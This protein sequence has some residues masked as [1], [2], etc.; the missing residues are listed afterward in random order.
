MFEDFRMH[1]QTKN[2]VTLV[3]FPGRSCMP[4]VFVYCKCSRTGQAHLMKHSIAKNT[5]KNCNPACY[6][7]KDILLIKMSVSAF[8]VNFQH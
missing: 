2:L 4:P 3:L 5:V 7:Y 8:K 1:L 6:I